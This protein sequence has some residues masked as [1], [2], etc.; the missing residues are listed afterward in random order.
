MVDLIPAKCDSE[1]PLPKMLDCVSHCFSFPNN[2]GFDPES[3][4]NVTLVNSFINVAD[5]GVCPK[6]ADQPLRGLTVRNTTIRSGFV[7][8]CLLLFSSR[9]QPFD[10]YLWLCTDQEQSSSVPTLTVK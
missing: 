7:H 3:C 5:D 6:A 4:T 8:V 2:D 9:Q 10:F 1:N